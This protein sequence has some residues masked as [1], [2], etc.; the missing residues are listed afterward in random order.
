MLKLVRKSLSIIKLENITKKH[1]QTI[2][3]NVCCDI[4]EGE[5]VVITGPSGTGKSTLLQII[6][7]LEPP[8]SGQYILGG[9]DAFKQP[10][11]KVA[12]LRHQFIGFIFQR[13]HLVEHLNIMENVLLPLQYGEHPDQEDYALSL[14]TDLG[15]SDHIYKQPKMLSYGQQQRVSIA[16][17]VITQPKVILA[18]EPTGSL[19][20][21]NSIKVM[22]SLRNLH[23]KGHTIIL[24][25]H[26]LSLIQP[27]DTHLRIHNKQLERV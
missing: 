20:K 24:I 18:D 12:K 3:N 1:D 5:F 27:G 25:T 14:L 6:G 22:Q 4:N 17:A 19:D 7:L 26:D 13:Y 8:T 11:S 9:N 21:D 15:L 10:P 16:R 23:K 2:L